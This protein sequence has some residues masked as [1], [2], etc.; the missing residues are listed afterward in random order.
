MDLREHLNAVRKRW[1][2][3]V[4]AVVLAI[5]GATVLTMN[6]PPRYAASVTFFVSTPTSGTVDAYQGNLFSE[7]RV[8]SYADLL[9]SDRL[10]RAVLLNTPV[11]L[12]PEAIAGRITAS[13]V[14]STVLL[15]ATVTDTDRARAL[16]LAQALANQFVVLVQE[17]ETPSGSQNPTVRVEVVAGP[18]LAD[19]PVSPQPVRNLA[20]AIVL[21]TLLGIAS[22]ELRE[23]LDGTVKDATTLQA[24]TGTPVLATV[25]YDSRARKAPLI[26]EGG[27]RSARAEALRQLRTNLQFVGVDQPAKVIVVT[28]AVPGEGKSVSVCNLA[29]VLAEAGN[30]VVLI[31]ADL[32]QPRLADYLGLEGAIGLTNVLAGQVELSRAIQQWGSR[33]LWVLPSGSVPPNPSELLGSRNMAELLTM[34]RANFDAVIVDTPPLL[35]VTD[36]AVVAGH[37]DGAVLLTRCGKT[38]AAQVR[39][40]HHALRVADARLVGCVLNMAPAGRADSYSYYNEEP[41]RGSVARPEKHLNDPQWTVPA[42][43]PDMVPSGSLP[44]AMTVSGPVSVWAG[45]AAVGPEPDRLRPAG[46]R[47]AAARSGEPALT[48]VPGR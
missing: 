13:P 2:L 18:R 35:P 5:G 24:L 32:R 12:T 23:M 29:I 16:Q 38:S 20:L 14:A 27:S 42:G 43:P 15:R 25:P 6:S 22:A 21:G 1:W 17:L 39:A 19:A 30:R 8:K 36:A 10:A 9:T 40:A 45:P 47:P 31:D 33:G 26:V 11:D 34:L 4:G 3:V 48:E 44:G 28:S 7:Q 46:S 37:A 41:A